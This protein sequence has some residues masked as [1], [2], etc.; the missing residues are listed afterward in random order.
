MKYLKKFETEADKTAWL[1][2]GEFVTPNVVLTGDVIGYNL[3]V[4]YS[5]L[6]LHIEALNDGLTVKFS[7]NYEYSKDNATWLSGTSDTSISANT[8]EKVYFRASG[9]TPDSSNGIGHFTIS[10]GFCNIA[11]NIMSMLFGADYHDKLEITQSYAFSRLFESQVYIKSASKLV[12][13]ATTL[14]SYC[15]YKTFYG[16]AYL[17]DA[18]SV[19]PATVLGS[20]CYAQT[21]MNCS[22]LLHAPEMLAR[23]LASAC[24]ESMYKNCTSLVDSPPLRAETLIQ[25]CYRYM[26]ENTALVDAPAILATTL[27]PNCC[28][29][30][31]QKSTKLVRGPELLARSLSQSCYSAMFYNCSKLSYIKAMFTTTPTISYTDGWLGGVAASGTFIKNSAANW[32]VTGAYGIPSGWTVET[33]D[34]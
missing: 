4:D 28:T 27:A 1:A 34:A 10:S 26:F 12:L 30:M 9:L 29:G 33:A 18:P 24:C 20:N 11:G 14:S 2:G 7:N 8:G 22:R 23:T 25:Y 16:C 5:L 15:Y 32:N 13:P 3:E 17:V 21:F 6:P 31:F 19:L